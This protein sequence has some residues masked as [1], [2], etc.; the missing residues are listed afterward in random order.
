MAAPIRACRASIP[1]D[2]L[3]QCFVDKRQIGLSQQTDESL[4][5]T[6]SG[7]VGLRLWGCLPCCV[8]FHR[9]STNCKAYWVLTFIGRYEK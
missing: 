9:S 4:S 2:S 8:S 6:G 5:Q 7:G 3:K 1:G